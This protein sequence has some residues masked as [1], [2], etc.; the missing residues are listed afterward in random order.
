MCVQNLLV[1][2]VLDVQD[3]YNRK[4]EELGGEEPEEGEGIRQ[5][6]LMQWYLNTQTQK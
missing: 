1:K 2:K 3:E 6:D 5:Q 4:V